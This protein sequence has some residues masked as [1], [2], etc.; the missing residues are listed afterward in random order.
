MSIIDLDRG[1]DDF[2]KITL[3]ANLSVILDYVSSL[4][5]HIHAHISR[6]ERER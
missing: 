1:I 5:T 6:R 3:L 4:F 2:R